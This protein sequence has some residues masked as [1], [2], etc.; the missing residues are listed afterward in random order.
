MAGF[1]TIGEALRR[2][3]AAW[4]VAANAIPVVGVLFFDWQA[5]PLLVFYWIENVVIGAF[6]VVKIFIAGVT[7]D[8]VQRIA[9]F[10]LVPFFI[11]H[12]GL[13]CFVHGIFVFAMFTM[14]DAFHGGVE[15]TTE[16]FDLMGRVAAMLQADS[17]LMWSTVALGVVQVGAFG[18]FWLGGRRWRETDAIRQMFEPYGRIVVMHLTIFI[19]TIPVLIIGQPMLAVLVLALLKSGLDLG[20]KPFQVATPDFPSVQK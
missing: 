2:P 13:F 11:L 18:I 7:K 6:N 8:G 5:L 3:D 9:S 17:D 4:I 15:P 16:S 10:F 12:Y 14:S 20:L 19:A 1:N